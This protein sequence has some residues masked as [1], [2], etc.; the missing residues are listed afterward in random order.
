MYEK[1]T[2]LANKFEDKVYPESYLFPVSTNKVWEL[3]KRSHRH[4]VSHENGTYAITRDSGDGNLGFSDRIFAPTPQGVFMMRESMPTRLSLY[5]TSI[6]KHHTI[7]NMGYPTSMAAVPVDQNENEGK[8]LLGYDNGAVRS[9]DYTADT[10]GEF[11]EP[12]A[13]LNGSVNSMSATPNKTIRAVSTNSN[14]MVEFD[15]NLSVTDKVTPNAKETGYR[16]VIT[17]NNDTLLLS[18]THSNYF[19]RVKSR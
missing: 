8:V 4:L 3:G 2:S 19:Y 9:S 12:V 18:N 13:V 6:I 15:G 10:L 11:S 16:K 7:P 14:E 1:A 5:G 17:D